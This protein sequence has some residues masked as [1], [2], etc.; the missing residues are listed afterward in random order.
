MIKYQ[1]PFRGKFSF[2]S[3]FGIKGSVWSCGRHT[4]VDLFSKREGGDGVVYPI[5]DGIVERVVMNDK[6]YGNYII[7]RH[8][9]GHVSLY[10]HLSRIYIVLG[11]I[12]TLNTPLG[13]EGTTGNSSAVHLHLEVHKDKYKY[14]ADWSLD[15]KA[16]I[17]KKMED[18]K[19]KP[20][21]LT[22]LVDGKARYLE[23]INVEGTNYVKLRDIVPAL[24]FSSAKIGWDEKDKVATVERG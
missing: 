17:E 16:F 9:D 13:M 6:S 21:Q 19:L 14:P 24:G 7:V 10:A 22:I 4:G 15:P 11:S 12:V 1:F 20:T 8:A 5:T 3:L 23:A 18:A 2:G